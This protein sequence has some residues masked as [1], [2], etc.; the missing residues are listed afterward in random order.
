MGAGLTATAVSATTVEQVNPVTARPAGVSLSGFYTQKIVWT[1]CPGYSGV[2]C[3]W[4]KVP[5]DYAHPSSGSIRLKVAVHPAG[6]K[7]NLGYLFTNPGGPG[8]SGVD[9]ATGATGYLPAA[10][11][12][13]YSVVGI[14]PRGVGASSPI[15]CVSRA[16]LDTFN[17][18]G[19]KSLSGLPST[20]SEIASFDAMVKAFG[21]GCKA[22]NPKLLEHVG[23]LDAARDMDVVR[24]VLHIKKLTYYGWSYGT[25]LGAW[26][27]QLF[28]KNV[29][30]FVLDGP[31]DPSLDQ[32][33][34]AH[35]QLMAF[36]LE[37]KRFLADCPKHSNCPSAL[38]GTADANYT[39]FQAVSN[40]LVT[41]PAITAASRQTFGSQALTQNLFLT[42]VLG[43][44]YDDSYGWSLLRGAL[45]DFL[46]SK[47][48]SSLLSLAYYEDNKDPFTGAYGD[49]L[50]EA[51]NA[52]SCYDYQA[53]IDV[54]NLSNEIV[55]TWSQQ[56]PVFGASFAWEEQV[57]AFWPAHSKVLPRPLR[58]PGS[59]TILVVGA[60]YDPA[61][62][63]GGAVSLAKQLQHAR[64]L[65]WNGD[66][67]T[68][69]N[70]GSACVD[71]AVTAYLLK[72]TLPPVGKMCPAVKRP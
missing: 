7:K 25:Y 20:P 62:P 51:F 2:R 36:E 31:V 15:H 52:I 35:A 5:I 30:R 9:V 64:L 46:S 22:R 69:Y 45:T 37:L 57:C 71:S 10:I 13:N 58:A 17:G 21:A 8:A 44:L 16:D 47:D 50:V 39:K 19:P 49:N 27:A 56:A 24:I 18:F 43:M 66:G 48:P 4:V 33:T 60:K 72:G 65:S 29:N 67:H 6:A 55:N 40:A 70:R 68:S 11:T 59:K 61:T 41:N 26:Y 23:T 12:K 32:M 54:S 3:T 28:P 53:P 34:G 38:R 42:A 1:K 14:D 63:Y